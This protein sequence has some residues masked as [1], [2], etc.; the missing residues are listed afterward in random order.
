MNIYKIPEFQIT[1]INEAAQPKKIL[2][3][4]ELNI[5]FCLCLGTA[6]QARWQGPVP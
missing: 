6:S 3:C 4:L 5:W 2:N 1:F